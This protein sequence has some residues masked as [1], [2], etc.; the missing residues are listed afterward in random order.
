MATIKNLF[1]SQTSAEEYKRIILAFIEG[2]EAGLRH[3]TYS[4]IGW[5]KI[6]SSILTGI[7]LL[8]FCYGG[9]YYRGI[10][11]FLS[12]FSLITYYLSLAS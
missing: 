11:Q 6:L 9:M 10:I 2:Y 7:A 8:V 1:N 4:T 3:Q 12:L 5:F